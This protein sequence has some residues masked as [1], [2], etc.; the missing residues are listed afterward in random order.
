MSVELPH[1]RVEPVEAHVLVVEVDVDEGSDATVLQHL[2]A[3]GRVALGEIR[4]QLTHRGSG[5]DFSRPAGLVAERRGMRTRLTS[6][7]AGVSARAKLD[8]VDVL[9]DR[10]VLAADW[11]V[12]IAPER[13]L[14][15]RPGER[16]EHQ[17]A[18]DERLADPERASALRSSATSR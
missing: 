13:D 16:V 4:E 7:R 2:P 12:G 15:E 3:E 8:V 1:R 17:E 18:A 5:V 9:R 10:R 6:R 11:A 14:R